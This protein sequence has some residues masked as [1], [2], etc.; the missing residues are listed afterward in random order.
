MR[1]VLLTAMEIEYR[2]LSALIGGE[3]HGFIG[4]HE[5]TMAQSGIGKVNAAL[6]VGRLIDGVHPDA[7]IST[8]LCGGLASRLHQGDL[9]LGTQTAYHDVWCGMGNVWGQVQGL[10]ARFDADPHLLAIGRQV[11]TTARIVEGV[12]A[13]GDCFVQDNATREQILTHLPDAVAC[14]MESAAIAHTCHLAG[15]PFLSLRVVS[16]TPGNTDNHQQ[17][18]DEFLASMCDTSFQFVKHFL[19]SL[20][21]N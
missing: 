18:W 17:Q 1:L 20:P 11:S 12:I 21:R 14:D 13:T 8:G 16:D 9:V 4:S 2:H 15:I 3:G 10:P 19:E 6:T 7:V 5:V